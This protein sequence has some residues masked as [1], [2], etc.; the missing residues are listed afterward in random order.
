MGMHNAVMTL[1]G[2]E[3]NFKNEDD[4]EVDRKC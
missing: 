2:E 3:E 1:E 4:K